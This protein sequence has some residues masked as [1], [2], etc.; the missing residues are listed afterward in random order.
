[1][2]DSKLVKLDDSREATTQSRPRAIS[3]ACDILESAD[4][5]LIMAEMPGVE[6]DAVEIQMDRS[7]LTIEATRMMDADRQ[8]EG[9]IAYSRAFEIP[10][11]VDVG[12][13]DA[14]MDNGVLSVHL[15]KAPQA[16]VRRINV[17]AG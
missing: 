17:S 1:M 10:D 16:R 5:Y 7:R 2:S 9:S 12:N 8:A 14:K 13:V 15:P 6:R 3:P 4:E 11:T